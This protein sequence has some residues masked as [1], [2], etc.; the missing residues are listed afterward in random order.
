MHSEPKLNFHFV[1]S[2]WFGNVCHT[3][4]EFNHEKPPEILG[5]TDVVFPPLISKWNSQFWFTVTFIHT[6]LSVWSSGKLLKSLLQSESGIRPFLLSRLAFCKY[7]LKSTFSSL[8]TSTK[9][10]SEVISSLAM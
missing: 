1:Y 7:S 10:L 8:S 9:T 3:V 6:S 4:Q 2:I 5:R